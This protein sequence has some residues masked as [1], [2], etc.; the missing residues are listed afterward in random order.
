LLA[1]YTVQILA[2][3]ESIIPKH[4]KLEISESIKQRWINAFDPE[5]L[6]LLLTF[7]LSNVNKESLLFLF[8][9]S[10]IN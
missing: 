9:Q 4:S 10:N 2:L 3:I 8:H 7:D 1:T 5:V 6:Q